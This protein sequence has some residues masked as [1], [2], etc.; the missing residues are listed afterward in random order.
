MTG[1]GAATIDHDIRVQCVEDH[2]WGIVSWLWQAFRQDLAPVV[3]GYPYADG[4]Y[5]V[6]A[7]TGSSG[8]ADR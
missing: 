1:T 4:R 7:D 8:W 2:E 5:Q 3:Q 6:T